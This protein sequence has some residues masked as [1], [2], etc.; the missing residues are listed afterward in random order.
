MKKIIALTLVAACATFCSFGC[1]KK[2]AADTPAAPTTTTSAD[3]TATEEA[4]DET[5]PAADATDAAAPA[6]DEAAA[7]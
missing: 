2:D 3:T 1:C 6:A 5:A 4:A 7:E